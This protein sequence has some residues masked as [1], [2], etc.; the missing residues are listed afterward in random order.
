MYC[1]HSLALPGRTLWCLHHFQVTVMP[2]IPT[3]VSQSLGCRIA[4]SFETNGDSATVFK[5]IAEKKAGKILFYLQQRV[6]FK[7]SQ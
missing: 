6:D 3:K 2:T 4:F 7:C 5:C 1:N